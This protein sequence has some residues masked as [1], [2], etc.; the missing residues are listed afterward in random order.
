[1]S[2]YDILLKPT[3]IKEKWYEVP[4]IVTCGTNKEQVKTWEDFVKCAKELGYD[5]L[6]TGT[7]VSK[8]L[9]KN[10]LITFT[11]NN[12]VFVNE[13][14]LINIDYNKMTLLILLFEN[15]L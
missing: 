3:R 8:R 11:K 10:T 4:K 7:L 9:E 1:M 2:E 13:A 12:D 6:S 5:L 14:H 15:K